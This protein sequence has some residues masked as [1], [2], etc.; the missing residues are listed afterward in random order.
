MI[1]ASYCRYMAISWHLN[2]KKGALPYLALMCFIPNG[3]GSSHC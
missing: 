2:Q 3:I 1:K